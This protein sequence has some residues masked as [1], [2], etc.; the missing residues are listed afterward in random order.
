[1]LHC[2]LFFFLFAEKRLIG[3]RDSQFQTSA[4]I[5]DNMWFQI[6][7]S[8]CGSDGYAVLYSNTK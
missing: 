8:V 2:L 3:R 6:S 7:A 1:M 5:V 4:D